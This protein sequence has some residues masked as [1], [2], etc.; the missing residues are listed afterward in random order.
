MNVKATH[1]MAITAPIKSR[2]VV[3]LI[4][5]KKVSEAETILSN[6]NKKSAR[7]VKKVLVSAVAN[8]VNNNS[9]DKDKLFVNEAYIDEG[10]VLKRIRFGSRS[11]IDR[12]DKR[13]SHITVVVGYKTK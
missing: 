4:R 9:L 2:L 12:H 11:H 10:P 6:I 7:L 13:T 3:D 5:G 1:K 8:A